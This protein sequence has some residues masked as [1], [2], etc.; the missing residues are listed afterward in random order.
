VLDYLNKFD[1]EDFSEF[2]W[3][4]KRRIDTMLID[5]FGVQDTPLA[6]VMSRLV[7]IASV[8]RIKQ[9][10]VKYDYMI[11]LV[12]P[13]N[14]AKSFAIQVLYDQDNFTDQKLIGIDDKQLA[15]TVRGKWAAEAADLAGMRKVESEQWK[16]QIG[17]QSD[18]VRPAYGRAVIEVPRVT[19][20]WGTTNN[21]A[22]LKE[23]HG[24]RRM[25]PL[26]VTGTIDLEGLAR[27]RDM[28]WA[29]AVL[30]EYKHKGDLRMPEEVWN[31]AVEAQRRHTEA[32]PW[33][34][35]LKNV[36]T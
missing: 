30:A 12:G 11:V 25:V 35:E 29:E 24:N 15:E 28:L 36:C 9:P 7:M 3:D 33:E 18:R 21:P 20:L 34:D 4:G 13:Q 31:E 23:A 1:P 10:G 19:V 2:S 6:R 8:R 5:Y 22:F 27:D 17:R 26:V 14:K 32:D 16:A